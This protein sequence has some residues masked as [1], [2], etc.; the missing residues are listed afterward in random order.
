MPAHEPSAEEEGQG[1]DDRE[2]PPSVVGEPRAEEVEQRREVAR[3]RDREG[4]AGSGG[5]ADPDA[6][7][8]AGS[9]LGG[10][11]RRVVTRQ[12][13]SGSGA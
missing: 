12:G 5:S 10:Q 1:R 6:R 11:K 2:Q 3:G 4:E 13:R 9:D 7:S 8:G